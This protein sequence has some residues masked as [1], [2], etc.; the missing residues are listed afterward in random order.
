[1]SEPEEFK[2]DIRVRQR[3]LRSNRLAGADLEQRMAK[4]VDVSTNGATVELKQPALGGREYP[5]DV[6]PAPFGRGKFDDLPPHPPIQPLDPPA[7]DAP[8]RPIDDEASTDSGW[9]EPS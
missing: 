4:L 2:F 5:K 1:M 3:M 8:T 7:F 9:D 6:L